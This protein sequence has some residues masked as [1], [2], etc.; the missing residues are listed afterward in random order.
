VAGSNCIGL[1]AANQKHF[2]DMVVSNRQLY[3]NLLD[4]LEKTN[5]D[6]ES[7]IGKATAVIEKLVPMVQ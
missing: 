5:V 2:E 4:Q 7:F 6:N 1:V 3:K